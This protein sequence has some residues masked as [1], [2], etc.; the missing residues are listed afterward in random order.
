[1]QE[2]IGRWQQGKVKINIEHGTVIVII[3]APNTWQTIA[4]RKAVTKVPSRQC[5]SV[6]V[7]HLAEQKP[8]Q[9]ATLSSEWNQMLCPE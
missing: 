4:R 1:M 7:S 3:V 8:P 5:E 6:I 2:E 9:L